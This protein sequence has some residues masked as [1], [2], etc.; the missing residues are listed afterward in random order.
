[1]RAG[2]RGVLSDRERFGFRRRSPVLL[3]S[4]H[5]VLIGGMFGC[6]N[7]A[8]LDN[9]RVVT[10]D[11]GRRVSV[12]A[13]PMRLISLAPSVTEILFALGLGSRVVGVTTYCDYPR[14]AAGITKVGDTQRPNLEKI[15]SLKPD[16]VIVS[17]AS[18]LEEFMSNLERLGI[19]VYVNNPT[20]L[21]SLLDS[22]KGIGAVA[23]VPESA[24]KL[25]ADLSSRIGA[26]HSRVAGLERPRVLFVLSTEPLITAGGGTFIND[27]ITE[28]GGESVSADQK[29]DYP[30]FSL[31]TA[32]ARRPEVIF[33]QAG[34]SGLP[35]QLAETPAAR[36]G[37]VYQL[38]DALLL[39]PGPR[40]V[41]GVEE[42]ARK[43]HP[44]AFARS[45]SFSVQPSKLMAASSRPH[46]APQGIKYRTC[47]S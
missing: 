4:L 47:Y 2:S 33:L 24:N 37:R 20:N 7:R 41:D 13:V 19:P 31:E 8:R 45:G 5:V 6:T 34:G 22:I 44:E 39:R 43:L 38:D 27:L 11:L 30:Q 35:K 14:E 36:A 23:G 28:A 10:D 32:L 46:V 9:S 25:V 1:M 17:T 42:V 21:E 12:I 16:L 26:V 15:I 18:Q 40:I 3:L 29:A